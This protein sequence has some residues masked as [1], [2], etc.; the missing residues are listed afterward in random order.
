MDNPHY[1]KQKNTLGGDQSGIYGRSQKYIGKKGNRSSPQLD[2]GPF[3]IG[4]PPEELIQK[5]HSSIKSRR[6]QSVKNTGQIIAALSAGT[7]N[8]DDTKKSGTD[9][10]ELNR[11]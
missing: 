6:S 7:G 2:N 3:H 5:N 11:R 4:Y 10:A 1:Q 9:A 8:Q